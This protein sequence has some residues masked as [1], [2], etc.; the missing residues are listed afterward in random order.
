MLATPH[1]ALWEPTEFMSALKLQSLATMENPAQSTLAPHPPE[2]ASTP[3]LQT[4]PFALHLVDAPLILIVDPLVSSPPTSTSAT[5]QFVTPPPDLARLLSNKDALALKTLIAHK[6]LSELFALSPTKPLQPPLLSPIS[7]HSLPI[8]SPPLLD[9]PAIARRLQLE[10]KPALALQ[11][12]TATL[13]VTTT[14]LAPLI[15]A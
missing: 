2:L 6:D 15:L 13:T 3:T 5:R 1:N 11:S 9:R 4:P 8:V 12:A 10:T 7:A 14:I